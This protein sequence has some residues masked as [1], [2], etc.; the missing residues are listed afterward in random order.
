MQES[1]QTYYIHRTLHL[2]FFTLK[3][4]N[5]NGSR[6]L[7]LHPRVVRRKGLCHGPDFLAIPYSNRRRTDRPIIHSLQALAQSSSKITKVGAEDFIAEQ[8]DFSVSNCQIHQTAL[9]MLHPAKLT[10][11]TSIMVVIDRVDQHA[12]LPQAG[13]STTTHL[14]ANGSWSQTNQSWHG[15]WQ[16][17]G[18]GHSQDLWDPSEYHILAVASLIQKDQSQVQM[19][20]NWH[21]WG[22]HHEA[23]HI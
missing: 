20:H 7:V 12:Q 3:T 2:K 13:S 17:H 1:H 18:W 9:F 4:L 8:L 15:Q 19:G 14:W 23:Y 22:P 5:I 11:M 21:C 10:P 16:Y 6:D